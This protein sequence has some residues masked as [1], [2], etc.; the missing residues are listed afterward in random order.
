MSASDNNH[1]QRGNIVV[2]KVPAEGRVP[3][4]FG[5]QQ[6]PGMMHHGGMRHQFLRM[7]A[8][9]PCEAKKK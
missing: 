5:M 6:H 4:P 7:V 2:A 3:Y 9:S 8:G 1:Q